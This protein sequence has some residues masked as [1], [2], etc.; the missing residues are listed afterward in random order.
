MDAPVA[1]C[2]QQAA[3]AAGLPVAVA[4]VATVADISF[5]FLASA[6]R[7]KAQ[8]RRPTGDA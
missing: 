2:L 4:V 7:G 3:A 8:L 5:L 6:H 1:C